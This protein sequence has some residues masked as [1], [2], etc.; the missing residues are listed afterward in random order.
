MAAFEDVDTDHY[1]YFLARTA[2]VLDITQLIA[3]AGTVATRA[4][5]AAK[6][7]ISLSGKRITGFINLCCGLLSSILK[8]ARVF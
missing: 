4:L 1:V 7:F 6:Q 8:R 3:C 5:A 2:A